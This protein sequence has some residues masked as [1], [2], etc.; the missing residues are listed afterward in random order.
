MVDIR[1][2]LHK[3]T[4]ILKR[5]RLIGKDID[6]IIHFLT[7]LL[8]HSKSQLVSEHNFDENNPVEFVV[9]V[10]VAWKGS[11]WRKM[12]TAVT[13][14]VR[15]AAFSQ[16]SHV[17]VQNMFIVSEP[18]AAAAAVL[19]ASSSVEVSLPS[20][21]SISRSD[22]RRLVKSFYSWMPV[23]ALWT[24]LFSWLDKASHCD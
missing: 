10:P 5:S 13:Q 21:S 4:D 23:E 24:Q 3:T 19:S 11:A 18:E 14:G 16:L 2:E 6:I 15:R 8:Q 20:L 9:C 7:R 12:Q 22:I 1:S 17:S